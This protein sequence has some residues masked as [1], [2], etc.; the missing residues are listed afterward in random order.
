MPGGLFLAI[1]GPNGAGKSSL[2]SALID[3]YTSQGLKAQRVSEPS[4]YDIGQLVKKY[5]EL[6][7]APLVL[8]C[9][10]AADRYNNLAT[11]ILPK[12]R[13]GYLVISDRYVA[14]NF[15][16]QVLQGVPENFLLNLNALVEK[17][18]LTILLDVDPDI[19]RSQIRERGSNSLSE[20]PEMLEKEIIEYSRVGTAL[21]KL[22]HPYIR[23]KNR[24][25]GLD[26]LVEEVC[27]LLAN[28]V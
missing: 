18:D 25:D 17:P 10:L 22:G 14:S 4:A 3:L 11:E 8:A 5:R 12:K 24:H 1:E 2:S 28:F 26:S 13:E 19:L 20:N 23:I 15:V 27:R 6:P 21:G 16:Y 7:D 9:L